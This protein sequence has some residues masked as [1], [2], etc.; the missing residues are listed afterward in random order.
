MCTN[1]HSKLAGKI[2]ESTGLNPT[3]FPALIERLNKTALRYF[4]NNDDMCIYQ[5]IELTEDIPAML[6]IIVEDLE[7]QSKKFRDTWQAGISSFLIEKYPSLPVREQIKSA[8][9]AITPRKCAGP[10]NSFSP[11]QPEF[12][13]SYPLPRESI[14]FVDTLDK[15]NAM[16]WTGSLVGIDCE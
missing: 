14:I 13:L 11:L 10:S 15:L 3:D 8:L 2:V 4:L 12:D 7:F 9:K 1:K 5:L 6:G 16:Q